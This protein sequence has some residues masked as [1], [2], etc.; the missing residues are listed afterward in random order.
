MVVKWDT[1]ITKATVPRALLQ[2]DL[3]PDQL[4]VASPGD[5]EVIQTACYTLLA[6]PY[7]VD[8]YETNA[9]YWK[10]YDAQP[11]SIYFGAHNGLFRMTPAKHQSECWEYDPRR[12]PWFVAASSG[13][14]DV[15]LVL[16]ISQSMA[17]S[18]LLNQ[19]FT[20]AKDAAITVIETL[21]LSDKIAVVLINDTASVLTLA[22]ND[23][24]EQLV[25][26]SDDNKDE[27]KAKIK[28]LEADG[29]SNYYDALDR[30]FRVLSDSFN[31]EE[32]AAAGSGCNVAVIFL[33]DGQELE[34]ETERVIAL[35]Q[36]RTE[37]LN[38]NFSRKITIF[39]YSVGDVSDTDVMKKVACNTNGIYTHISDDESADLITKMGAY[40]QLFASGLGAG[41]NNEDF[42]AWV[43][44]YVFK[45]D[46]KLG[47]TV[48]VPVF[49]RSTT[50]HLFLGVVGVD[51]Y[52]DT[53]EKVL[54]DVDATEW[55]KDNF[56]VKAPEPCPKI[57]PTQCQLNALRSS[58]GG[59]NATCEGCSNYEGLSHMS[60][61]I[62]PE[63]VYLWIDN[64]RK[65]CNQFCFSY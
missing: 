65:C 23:N 11:G 57:E 20:N 38:A 16:D 3:D 10:K 5:P 48:S 8:S 49:D 21:T 35:V 52:M 54:K 19:R 1:T 7:M 44:P 2:S 29:V 43:E 4:D 6:E 42:I 30:T 37:E 56:V 33:T 25:V 39:V 13:P 27:L 59:V 50:P 26:A 12:R 36:N 31:N 58:F 9:E 55:V 64:A 14:K 62:Q 53:I 47:T 45:S 32:Y 46:G 17:P 22:S 63:S 28:S 24:L 60:C 15:V 40:Y 61:P 18:E 51:V 41:E 34:D